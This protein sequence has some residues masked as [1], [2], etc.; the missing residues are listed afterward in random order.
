MRNERFSTAEG[1]LTDGFLVE[2]R[3]LT[4]LRTFYM[5]SSCGIFTDIHMSIIKIGVATH[6]DFRMHGSSSN[7]VIIDFRTDAC[8]F[9]GKV[10]PGKIYPASV[11]L[12]H[13][14]RKSRAFVTVTSC[15]KVFNNLWGPFTLRE[16]QSW[17][18]EWLN[19]TEGMKTKILEFLWIMT[20]IESWY[21]LIA[22][23]KWINWIKMKIHEGLTKKMNK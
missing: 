7:T 16:Y 20:W 6:F 13:E 9:F 3:I 15:E 19:V 11:K 21:C 1:P 23:M 4:E 17:I 18:V 2:F 10:K 8:S 5:R 12:L 22:I 14:R